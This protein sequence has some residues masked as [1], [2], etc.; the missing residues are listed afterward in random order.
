M[1]RTTLALV[2]LVA[3]SVGSATCGTE[4]PIESTA[5]GPTDMRLVITTNADLT[6]VH[7]SQSLPLTIDAPN[8]VLVAPDD[9]PPVAKES[10]AVYL[11]FHLDT[12]TSALLLVTAATSVSVTI[13]ADTKVGPHDLICRAHKHDS[14]APTDAVY[15]LPID[16]TSSAPSVPS[17]T[18]F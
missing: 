18:A 12:E 3:L 1:K 5:N 9:T 13:P 4:F 16:V 7:A 6:N 10:T 11:E 8:L 15:G 14:G 2:G 17:T